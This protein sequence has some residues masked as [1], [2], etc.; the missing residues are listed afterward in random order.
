VC[1]C[2]CTC[3]CAWVYVFVQHRDI[4][5]AIQVLREGVRTRFALPSATVLKILQELGELLLLKTSTLR[6]SP[7]SSADDSVYIPRSPLEEALLV[8]LLA[9]ELR[10]ELSVQEHEDDRD[11]T[12]VDSQCLGYT[13]AS[14]YASLVKVLC[15]C[16][17]VH[18]E[19]E[20]VC[21]VRER[22]CVYYVCVCVCI[23]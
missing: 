5:R 15:T 9:E 11:T 20:S 14:D 8:F 16:V 6:Y 10:T 17:L 19:R 3:V 18:C 23:S 1:V 2:V 22:E 7:P 13:L 4:P 12:I 21:I